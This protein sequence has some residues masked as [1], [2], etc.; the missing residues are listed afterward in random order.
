VLRDNF[1]GFSVTGANATLDGL[2]LKGLTYAVNGEEGS[3]IS[4]TRSVVSGNTYGAYVTS[5]T[6]PSRIAIEHSAL[7]GNSYGLLAATTSPTGVLHATVR[8]ALFPRTPPRACR[9]RAPSRL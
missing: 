8:V 7:T 3:T 1:V 5:N 9:S 6:T 2:L 4:I